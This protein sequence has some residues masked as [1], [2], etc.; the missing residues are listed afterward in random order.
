MKTYYFDIKDNTPRK[1]NRKA[2]QYCVGSGQAK[3]AVRT[4]Y[5]RQLKFI[6]EELGIRRVR[7][8]GI[9]DD[10]MQTVMGLDDF[11]PLPGSRKFWN[12]NFHNIAVAY[13]NVLA[14][15]MKPW[16]ELSFMPSRLAKSQKKVTVNAEG[17]SSMPKNDREWQALIRAF[18]RFLIRRYGSQEVE[19]WNFEVWNE[20][21]MSTFFSGTQQDYFH[22]YEI[23]AKA[24]K[25]VDDK[26]Q[27]GGPA[28]ATGAWIDDFIRFVEEKDLPCDFISTHNYPGDGIGEVFLGK[29]M[30]NAIVGGT[31]RLLARRSGR[32]LDGCQA[33]MEDKPEQS[34][35]PKGQMREMGQLLQ[36]QIRGRYPLYMTEWNCNAILMSQSNDD[37]KVAC[38]QIKTIDEMEEFTTGSSIWSFSDIFDE[39]LMIP[40]EFSG[41]FGLLTINCIPKP[42][43]HAL[44]L[45]A[46]T[47]TRKYD[48]P[49]T[50]DEI[51]VAV[52]ESSTEKRIFV[53]R[54]RMKNVNEPAAAYDLKLELPEGAEKVTIYRIDRDHCN[55]RRIWEE[56]GSPKEMSL[57]EIEEIKS[58]SA[59][60]P[61]DIEPEIKDDTLKLSGSLEVNDIHCYVVVKLQNRA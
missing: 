5:A 54:Q 56:M 49:Y 22:L 8:H 27:V 29:I 23:T 52:Y 40:D 24:V 11:M 48:L 39:F 60:V 14:A 12:Y 10:S 19:S 21:N 35:M 2:W 26:L 47:R 32:T 33:V 46:G 28:T 25:E 38:F 7:F 37:K 44:K 55:P 16:V 31:R 43:F 58:R 57:A 30:F 45:M 50:N 36:E 17:R 41:G 51:E 59:L 34:E 53:Y 13:D 6:H 18:L 15:G 4:D 1:E 61:E 9:F 3:L 42:Q 20:P